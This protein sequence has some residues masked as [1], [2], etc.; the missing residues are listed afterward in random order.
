MNYTIDLPDSFVSM[1]EA[2]P[3]NEPWES[4]KRKKGEMT[5][6]QK[7][8]NYR[9]SNHVANVSQNCNYFLF[10]MKVMRYNKY[11]FSFEII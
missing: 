8:L 6:N 2:L 7:S 3:L 1:A 10:A 11:N 4:T 9:N 5:E